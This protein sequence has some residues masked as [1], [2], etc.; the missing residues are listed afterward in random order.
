M[1]RSTQTNPTEK[2]ELMKNTLESLK[3]Q[4]RTYG[5][6]TTGVKEEVVER[7]VRFRVRANDIADLHRL[8]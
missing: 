3:N 4:C 7:L 8:E 5:L 1:T 6:G 2:D